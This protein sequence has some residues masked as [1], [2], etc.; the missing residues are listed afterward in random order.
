MAEGGNAA[1]WMESA[2]LLQRFAFGDRA[3][4]DGGYYSSSISLTPNRQGEATTAAG[5]IGFRVASV[6]PTVEVTDI[7]YSETTVTLDIE[8]NFAM[9][10][11]YRSQDLIL[12]ANRLPSASRRAMT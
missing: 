9:V 6:T 7:T 12:W 1:E 4:R 2:E 5:F 3:V 10:D 11:V 8:S